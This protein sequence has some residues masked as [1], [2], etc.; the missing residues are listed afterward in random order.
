MPA[1][2]LMI[3]EKP[4]AMRRI[5]EALAEKGS[6]KRVTGKNVKYYEFE[7]NGK[8]YVIVCA[9]GHLFSLDSLGNGKGWSYPI[10]DYEW[11]PS[12]EVRKESAFSKRYFD[13]IRMVAKEAVDYIV[14]TDFDT[15]GSAIGYNILKF[16]CG[17]ND[18]KRMKFSTLTKDELT[19]SYNA[20]S[21]H[22]DFGQAEAGLTRHELDWLWGINTTR[23]LT[24]ALKNFSKKGFT[25]L[26]SGRVQSPTLAILLERELEIR[27]FKPTPFW[28]LQLH[29]MEGQI[30]AKYEKDRLWNKEEADQ[31]L[32]A[33]DGKDA[34]VE[35]VKK[36]DY[37]QSAP[38][39]FN[40]TD[41]Q[42]EAY[43]QFMFS[44]TQ[45]MRIA[46][47]LYQQGFISYPRSSSQK[48]PPSINYGKILRA[49]ATNTQYQKFAEGLLK[50]E[51]LVPREG[52]REDPAHP[53]IYATWE[54]PYQK[55]LTYQ[56]RK[57]YD[58]I[59]RR[60]L[61]TFADD[62]LKQS[63]TYVLN[64]NSYKFMAVG[65]RT[66]KSGWTEIY[67]QYLSRKEV[68]LSEL[69]IGQIL[70]VSKLEELA[71]ETQP[72]ERFSQGSILKEME[73]RNLGTRATRAEILQ[74]LY[75]RKYIV[76]KSIKVKRLGEA[77][78]E[79]LKES[80]SRILSE[81][82][83][84]KFEEEMDSVYSGKKTRKN[85]VEDA[86]KTLTE[87][88][89]EFKKNELDIGRKLYEGLREQREEERRLGLCLK[90]KTGEMRVFFSRKTMKRFAGCSN[91]PRCKA[92]FPLPS[93]GS[94]TP[95]N[96]ACEA[97]GWP[98]I[99]VWR[100]GSRSFRMCINNK[101][102]SKVNW[103]K[104]PRIGGSTC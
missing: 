32:Q 45:T 15:E 17:A 3:S 1:Y 94:L 39:P 50:K 93:I 40:T 62:A 66:L 90:C 34:V 9:V 82:L 14:C 69:K 67:N 86:T 71:K 99:Q 5:A 43:S 101:C 72:P 6:L 70:K 83:T 68:V 96:R 98:V 102:A 36:R 55:K 48:L 28:Q 25:I 44:P 16:I 30:I 8:T 47:S 31:I 4:D 75:E 42:M 46:E 63:T 58:M 103:N 52:P 57:I 64:V 13:V 61:A 100:K 21:A 35:D 88:L 84:R 60:T 79:A 80:C 27:A 77:V 74:T 65:K 23:A 91:Y 78:A 18:G 2:T 20:M 19:E 7:R 92:G 12:F 87:V 53:A 11:K 81:E 24:L 51:I 37:K 76:G 29:L 41:L 54:I 10:F 38:V 59:T 26:S 49:L 85:V 95:L 73:N 97:C 33:C 22:L 56:Q 104:K 89:N